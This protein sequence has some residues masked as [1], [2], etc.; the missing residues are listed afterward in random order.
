VKESYLR[1]GRGGGVDKDPLLLFASAWQWA[2]RGFAIVDVLEGLGFGLRVRMRCGG[3]VVGW[4][5]GLA[6]DVRFADPGALGV[7]EDDGDGVVGVLEGA[8]EGVDVGGGL[9]G[10]GAVVVGDLGG[11]CVSRGSRRK[12]SGGGRIGGLLCMRE[13]ESSYE[14]VHVSVYSFAA[15]LSSST[16]S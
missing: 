1:A 8:D 5:E 7:G 12:W 3:A 16:M 13:I 6:D 10:G 9:E 4:F 14:D 11:G 15:R 2:G